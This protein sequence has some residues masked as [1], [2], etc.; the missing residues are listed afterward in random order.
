MTDEQQIQAR[1]KPTRLVVKPFRDYR[2]WFDLI[3]LA[4]QGGGPR[5]RV[6]HRISGMSLVVTWKPHWTRDEKLAAIERAFTSLGDGD[7]F[8][9]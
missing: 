1:D 2:L 6:R 9:V 3:P 5:R 7:S 8:C 4:D